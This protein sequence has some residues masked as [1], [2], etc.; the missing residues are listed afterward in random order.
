MVNPRPVLYV[1]RHDWWAWGVKDRPEF[2]WLFVGFSKFNDDTCHIGMG[3]EHGI[4]EQAIQRVEICWGFGGVL[5]H[6]YHTR[7]WNHT[8]GLTCLGPTLLSTI[9]SFASLKSKRAQAHWASP[10]FL[11]S[12]S[13]I[14]YFKFF[15]KLGKN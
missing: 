12:I 10:W 2:L 9:L 13:T 3:E 7:W 14:H 11:M 5:S 8:W 15:K 6:T 4:M 1:S